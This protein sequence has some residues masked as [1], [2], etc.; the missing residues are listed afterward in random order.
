MI[1]GM[2]V[3]RVGLKCAG[4]SWLER[5]IGFARTQFDETSTQRPCMWLRLRDGQDSGGG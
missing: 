3:A 1:V 2:A 5:G 4:R